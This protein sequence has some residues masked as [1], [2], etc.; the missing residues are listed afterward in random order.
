MPQL[1]DVIQS[2]YKNADE[3]RNNLISTGY[4]RDDQLSNHN[5]QV[6]Y[7]EA[8]HDLI[9]NTTGTHNKKDLLYNNLALATGQIKRTQRYMDAHQGLRQAKDKYK[10]NKA[11][12]TGDSL[13]GSIASLIHSKNS[14]KSITFNKGSTIGQQVRPSENSFRVSGDVISSL[15][16]HNKNVKTLKNNNIKTPFKLLNMYNAHMP[17]NLKKYNIKI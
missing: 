14:D 12:V 16:S 11:T 4:K 6:Y 17:S 3:Q 7:N 13:G 5:N 2:G 9:Y 8:K 15:N 1:Y 10:I